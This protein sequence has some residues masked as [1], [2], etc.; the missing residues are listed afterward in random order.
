[1]CASMVSVWVTQFKSIWKGKSHENRIH[2]FLKSKNIYI[3]Y[4]YSSAGSWVRIPY[5]NI[6]IIKYVLNALEIT[7]VFQMHL[8]VRIY[9]C[10]VIVS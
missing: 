3:F 5:L 2:F 9:I 7:L 1:M 4:F 6:L 8:N 10:T